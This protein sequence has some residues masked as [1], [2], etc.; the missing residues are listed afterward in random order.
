M[1]R[2]YRY[3]PPVVNTRGMILALESQHKGN[4]APSFVSAA[5]DQQWLIFL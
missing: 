2:Y 1:Y 3:M 5:M 4:N